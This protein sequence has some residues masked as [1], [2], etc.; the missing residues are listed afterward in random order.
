MGDVADK[1]ERG[2]AR[3]RGEQAAVLA[4]HA[5]RDRLVERLAV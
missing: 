5:D 3:G 4:G 1:A 2:F